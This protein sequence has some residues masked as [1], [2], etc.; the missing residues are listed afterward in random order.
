VLVKCIYFGMELIF[1]VICALRCKK[2]FY[3]FFISLLAIYFSVKYRSMPYI[4]KVI[5]CSSRIE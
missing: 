2:A 5:G 4:V 3:L 1:N